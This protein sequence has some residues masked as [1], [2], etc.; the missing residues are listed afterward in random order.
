[1]GALDGYRVID[2]TRVLGGPFATQWLGDHGA[3]IV[4]IEPPS[5]DE[6]R[7][8]GPPF[9]DTTAAA[10]Y[11]N[12]ANRN[13]RGMVLDLS[14]DE[15]R[16]VLLRFLET[17]DVLVENFR[18]GTLEKWGIGRDVLAE[19]FPRLV[20]CRITGFG[21][22]GPLGGLPGYDAVVQAQSGLMSVN[23]TPESGAVR[24]GIPLVD[25]AT[26]ISS[27]AGILMALLER[28][29][30]GRGQFIDMTLYDVGVS[31]LHPQGANWLTDGTMPRRM[32][33]A[34]PNICPYDAFPTATVPIFIAAANDGQF[35]KLCR[36]LGADALI[37]DDRFADHPSRNRNREALRD[38][39]VQALARFDGEVLAKDLMAQ[40]VPAGA[41]LDVPDVLAQEHTRHRGMVA[42]ADGVR[43]L[44]NPIAFSRTKPDPTRRRPPRF[45]EHTDEL[46]REA[47]FGED[48]IAA[49][50][51]DGTVR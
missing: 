35:R 26:G 32:G 13:K 8:W 9:D 22:D 24:M 19:R 30:S 28:E 48:E 38:A 23:G 18:P 14:R 17:A 44:G 42:E 7:H 5:G 36:I 40:G 21:E 43:V 15:G 37:V 2:L 45:G 16:A 12:G 51:A 27:M 49:L 10:S 3:D 46:M 50:R 39:L 29:R 25:I 31:L 33:N 11:F 41:V 20:H 47:G 6:T 4:K 34:H 1:M